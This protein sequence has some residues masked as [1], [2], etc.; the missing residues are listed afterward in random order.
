MPNGIDFSGPVGALGATSKVVALQRNSI[1][2]RCNNSRRPDAKTVA[3]QRI[4]VRLSGGRA[5][6]QPGQ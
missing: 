6:R 3:L 1:T 5:R 2:L 4:S